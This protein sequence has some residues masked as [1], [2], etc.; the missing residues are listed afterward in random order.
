MGYSPLGHHASPN[1]P[2]KSSVSRKQLL[3]FFLCFFFF[4]NFKSS[5]FFHHRQTSRAVSLLTGLAIFSF[6]LLW[7]FAIVRIFGLKR[8]SFPIHPNLPPALAVL[9]QATNPTCFQQGKKK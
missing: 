5:H 4:F 3:L 2:V 9:F 6:G 8:F 1:D 7:F